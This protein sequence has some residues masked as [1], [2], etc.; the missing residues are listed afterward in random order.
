M[1]NLANKI[2]GQY[3]RDAYKIGKHLGLTKQQSDNAIQNYNSNPDNRRTGAGNAWRDAVKVVSMP[4][5]D[6][7]NKFAGKEVF[8]NHLRTKFGQVFSEVVKVVTPI[9]V[10]YATPLVTNALNKSSSNL[11]KNVA[12]KLPDVNLNGVGKF[13]KNVHL[14]HLHLKN[15]GN[16]IGHFKH[17]L[18]KHDKKNM[19]SSLSQYGGEAMMS[20]VYLPQNLN[21]LLK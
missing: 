13:I 9:A 2:R 15:V 5:T 20:N 6:T 16:H 17:V 12:S 8:D 10:K 14:P 19:D 7:V 11:V 21:N 1:Q 3:Y 18:R 4:V